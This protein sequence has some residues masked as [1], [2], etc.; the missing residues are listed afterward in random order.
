VYGRLARQDGELFP[1]ALVFPEDGRI[2]IATYNICKGKGNEA[3]TRPMEQA[4]EM[5][6]R[7]DA[8]AGLLVSE[9]ADIVVLNELDFDSLP[10]GRINQAEY[11]AKKAGFPFLVEQRD[12]EARTLGGVNK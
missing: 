7:L 10:T 9:K 8:I 2:R 11:I 4:A 6:A 12:V 5:F 3:N 1:E